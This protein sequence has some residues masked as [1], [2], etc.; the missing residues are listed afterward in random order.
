M[1]RTKLRDVEGGE[2]FE[3][4]F[5]PEEKLE[6]VRLESRSHQYMYNDGEFYHFL[7]NESYEQ[8]ELNREDLGDTVPWLKEGED[9]DLM[10]Y[11]DR[12]MGLELPNTVEREVI[13]TE[14]G[15]KG[16]T[17]QGGTKP[18]TIEGDIK[19]TVPLFIENGEK[20]IA[21]TRSGEYVKRA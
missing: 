3:K 12:I 14:P 4:T 10:L 20:I 9:V 5:G 7:D 6:S 21:D 17:A 13:Y 11:E 2:T 15:V 16:D 1:I 18:A 19:V 8:R